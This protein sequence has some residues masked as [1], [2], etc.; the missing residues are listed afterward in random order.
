MADNLE[1]KH[2]GNI[3]VA[4]P[5]PSL[6]RKAEDLR[7]MIDYLTARGGGES[8]IAILK[9]VLCLDK[10]EWELRWE[11]ERA[12]HEEEAACDANTIAKLRETVAIQDAE[13]RRL[14]S[15]PDHK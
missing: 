7:S 11:A 8:D 3:S 5:R 13:I 6:M 1:W 2:E 14:K 15:E 4:T 12:E 9:W 10:S